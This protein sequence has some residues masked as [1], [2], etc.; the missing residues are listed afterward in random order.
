MEICNCL[1]KEQLISLSEIIS[2]TLSGTEKNFENFSET[3]LLFLEDISGLEDE[4]VKQETVKNLWD[5]SNN[6]I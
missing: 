1:T 3:A 2:E 5:I 6:K 4:S